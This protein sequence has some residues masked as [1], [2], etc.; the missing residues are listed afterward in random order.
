MSISPTTIRYSIDAGGDPLVWDVDLSEKATVENSDDLPE[1]TRLDFSQCECCPLKKEDHP[2]CPAAVRAHEVLTTFRNARS[3][4]FVTVEVETFQRQYRKALPLQKALQSLLGLLMS[5]SGCPILGRFRPL[6]SFHMPFSS[7][8]ETLFRTVGAYLIHQYFESRE[9]G[10][11]DWELKGLKEFY[12]V[13]EGLNRD[14]SKRIQAVEENDAISNAIIIFFATS[15]VVVDSIEDG[16]E[17][18]RNLFTA[19]PPKKDVDS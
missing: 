11:P 5:T 4:D 6:A 12:H 16:L 3:F 19:K 9:E 13:L 7:F 14:F 15:S 17:E 10:N 8:E 1:W 2:H 18:Y